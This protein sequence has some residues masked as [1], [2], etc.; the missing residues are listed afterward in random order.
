MCSEREAH[1]SQELICP[2]CDSMGIKRD[3]LICIDPEHTGMTGE[4]YIARALKCRKDQN[5]SRSV[6]NGIDHALK[7]KRQVIQ[8]VPSACSEIHNNPDCCIT[9]EIV[10][11]HA[12]KTDESADTLP[13]VKNH[14][15]NTVTGGQIPLTPELLVDF[16]PNKT[17]FLLQTI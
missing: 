14:G 17:S 3:V 1:Q 16:K 6:M 10:E 11:C 4:E 9:E 7:P 12:V 5:L 13:L 8:C 15:I 2:E